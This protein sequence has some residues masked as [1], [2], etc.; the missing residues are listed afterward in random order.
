LLR[1]VRE[2]LHH[3]RV[4]SIKIGALGSVSNARAIASWMTSVADDIPIVLDPVMRPTRTASHARLLAI[5]AKPI[6]LRMMK[7]VTLVTPNVPEAEYLLDRKILTLD[8]AAEAAREFVVL[9]ARAALV[10]GGHLPARSSSDGVT[11]IL[12]VGRRLVP[13]RSQRVKAAFHGTGCALSSLVAGRLALQPVVDDDAI[14]LAVRW[15]ERRLRRALAEP[16]RI[17][18]GLAVVNL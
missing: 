18:D 11:D 8:D 10:K 15:A 2:I 9:G 16:L 14:V 12:A 1:E 7:R 13:F 17:G 6:L 3:Q 5:G 4:R